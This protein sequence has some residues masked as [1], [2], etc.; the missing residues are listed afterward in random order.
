MSDSIAFTVPGTPVGKARARTVTQNGRTH[1]YTPRGTVLFENA[2]RL[3]AKEAMRGRE[4][5]KGAVKMRM[6]AYFRT[7]ASWSRKKADDAVYKKSK[8]DIDNIAKAVGDAVRGIC[9]GDDASVA[10]LEA[11]KLYGSEERVDVF[12]EGLGI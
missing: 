7:P 5:L 11:L 8:P 3:A 9:Y 1:S 12:F 10:W 6:T 2:V 4:P